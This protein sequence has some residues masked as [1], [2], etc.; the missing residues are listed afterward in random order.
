VLCSGSSLAAAAHGRDFIGFHC[1]PP[2]AEL[3]AIELTRGSGT[4]DAT[5]AEAAH[6]FH[7]LGRH[8]IRVTDAPGLVLGRIVCQLINEA[9]FAVQEGVGSAA[10]IDKGVQLGL[11]YPRGLLAWCDAIGADHVL[12]TLDALQ[13][14]IGGDRYRAAPLLRRMVAEGRTGRTAG[15]G[16]Y[17]Y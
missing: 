8:V 13:R 4:S 14:E 11:N 10:D 1:V 9:A 3:R 15:A 6:F 17:A 2:L 16:F 5:D 7:A 12:A